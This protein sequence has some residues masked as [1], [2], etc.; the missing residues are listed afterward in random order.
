MRRLPSKTRQAGCAAPSGSEQGVPGRLRLSILTAYRRW[1]ELQHIAL[2][3]NPHTQ[4]PAV[5]AKQL[6]LGC[7]SP[8]IPSTHSHQLR[9]HPP[10]TRMHASPLHTHPPQPHPPTLRGWSRLFSSLGSAEVR[11]ARRPSPATQPAS[12]PLSCTATYCTDGAGWVGGW[13]GSAHRRPGRSA[14]SSHYT[15][16]QILWLA[17]RTSTRPADPL[18]LGF[19]PAP[20][21]APAAAPTGPASPAGRVPC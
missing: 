3:A 7:Q 19:R 14:H 17:L 16:A 10:H 12:G 18:L 6:S 5:P 1:L 13:V 21:A 9:T 8:F 15:G 11:K 20:P 4:P 2:P